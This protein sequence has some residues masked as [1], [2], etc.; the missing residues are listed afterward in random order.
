MEATIYSIVHTVRNINIT[1]GLNVEKETT[2]SVPSA[3]T[4]EIWYDKTPLLSRNGLFNFVL[5]ARG[6]GK[7]FAYKKWAIKSDKQ[8][9]W[10]RRYQEDIDDLQSKF[11]GDLYQEGVI[12]PDDDIYIKNG[13]LY[14]GGIEKI[15]FVSLSTSARKKSQSYGGVDK[16]IYD[17]VFEGIGNRRYLANEVDL[18]LELYETVNRLRID[19][20]RDC[21]VFLLSNKTS[22]VNPYFTYWN[23]LPFSERFKTFKNGL[24]VVENYENQEFVRLKKQSKFGQLVEGTKYGDYAIDN[25]VWLDDSAFLGDKPEDAQRCICNIRFGETRFGVWEGGSVLYF[26]T[27][28]N[29]DRITFTTMFEASDNEYSL[30]PN[31]QPLKSIKEIFLTG[32]VLFKNNVIKNAVFTIIQT[33]GKMP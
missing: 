11:L 3:E 26:G 4:K 24:I 13:I 2:I 29:P 12:S 27:E 23:I 1:G 25:I 31:R 6:T 28:T 16:I 20:R 5:G 21:R 19:G 7:T 15:F 9:V 10:V 17:E 18:L 33:G 32:R 14:I 22:F 8:T 30:S